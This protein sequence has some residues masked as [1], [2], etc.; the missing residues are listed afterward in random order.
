MKPFRES[1]YY[2]ASVYLALF[3]NLG[4]I[5]CCQ[6]VLQHTKVSLFLTSLVYRNHFY[7]FFVLRKEATQVNDYVRKIG[8]L[9]FF[10]DSHQSLA[11]TNIMHTLNTSLNRD[12]SSRVG[13]I[14]P[15]TN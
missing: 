15:L 7:V 13:T 6:K 5:Y 10:F 1:D 9:A 11:C 2:L 14:T 8:T 3:P 4:R 12:R